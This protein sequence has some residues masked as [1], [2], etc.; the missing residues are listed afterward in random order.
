MNVKTTGPTKDKEEG[1]NGE[2]NSRKEE[3]ERRTEYRKI[4]YKQNRRK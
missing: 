1:M 3:E 4:K 2:I